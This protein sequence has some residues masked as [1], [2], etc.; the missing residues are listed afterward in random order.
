[1]CQMAQ[2]GQFPFADW[3]PRFHRAGP[4]TSLDECVLITLCS[5]LWKKGYHKPRKVAKAV[6]L[7]VYIACNV[8]RVMYFL[9]D[10][11]SVS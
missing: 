10:K 2:N 8:L 7:G 3:L 1:M 6:N 4:S 5:F 9:R 11:L